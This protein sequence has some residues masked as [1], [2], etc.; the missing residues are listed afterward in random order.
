[1]SHRVPLKVVPKPEPSTR[2]LL[3]LKPGLP[4]PLLR[5]TLPSGPTY[6]CGS[7]GTALIEGTPST[8][9]VDSSH[10]FHSGYDTWHPGALAAGE[11]LLSKSAPVL[12]EM[13]RLLR[14]RQTVHCF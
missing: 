7:C 8:Q 2:A 12:G 14:L 4:G 1:M 11:H 6:C 13:K 9:F 5:G 3:T 10:I